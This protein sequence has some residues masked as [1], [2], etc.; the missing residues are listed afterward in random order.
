MFP[1]RTLTARWVFPVD[2]PPLEGGTVGFAG[3][4]IVAVDPAG[5]RT[6]D[7]NLGNAAVIPGLVNCHTHLDL[8]GLRGQCPPTP[9]F[10]AWLRSVIRHRRAAS[11][12]ETRAAVRTGLAESLAAGVTLLGDVTARGASLPIL[13]AGAGRSVVFHEVLG[14][15]LDR[16]EKARDEVRSWLTNTPATPTCRPSVSPHAPYSVRPFLF[17]AAADL[18]RSLNVPLAT[19][20]AETREELELLATHSGPFVDFLTELGVWDPDGLAGS[21]VEIVRRCLRAA[22]ALLVHANYL[23]ADA[24][25]P[26]WATIIYCPRTH[27]AFGHAAH[28]FRG[29]LA[30]NV[31]V[32]LGTDGLASNPD[33][34]LLAE[35]QFLHSSFPDFP[36]AT[37]LRMATLSGAEAL[38]WDDETGSLTP[39][40]SA[41][42]VVVPLSERDA[43]DPHELLWTAPPAPRGVLWRGE[44]LHRPA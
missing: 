21:T 2:G 12:D 15:P 22:R 37:L 11:E 36:G 44:W 17:D 35:A 38:G 41:D 6:P 3:P 16:A 4:H 43:V 24:P 27:A 9:D 8:T 25:V 29:F 13:A 7:W 1:L 18:A 14:L 33:L 10:T 26:P 40:K 20:V 42:L 30:R 39:G 23:P 32:A 34:D 31:R 19:H 5:V 28:P